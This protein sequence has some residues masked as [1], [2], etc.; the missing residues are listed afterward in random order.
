MRS[1]DRAGERGERLA[2]SKGPA[3][4]DGE[5]LSLRVADADDL[6]VLASVLQ[7]AVIAIGDM[8]YIASD[9]LF[10]MLASRFRWEAV[11]DSEA[12]VEPGDEMEGEANASAFE[13]IHCGVAFEGVEAVKVKG[14]DMKDRSQF[15]DLLTLR[16]EDEGLILTFAGGGAIRLDVPRIRGHMRDMGEPWPTANKPEHELGEG[17]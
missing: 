7:D 5:R 11:F 4:S 10:V 13:R 8:R 1:G 16:A 2:G 6:A 9:K 15:L 14:I 3:G 12:E 17:G